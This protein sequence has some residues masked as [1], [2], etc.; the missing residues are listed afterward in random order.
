MKNEPSVF[1]SKSKYLEGLQCPKLL[2]YEFNRKEDFPEIALS[3]QFRFDQ[4]KK[5]GELAQKLFPGGI[6]LER[7]LDPDKCSQKSL[8]ALKQRKPLFEAGFVHNHGYAIADIIEPASDNAWDLIEVKS[9]ASVKDEHFYDVAFQKY[10]YEGAG[11]KIRDCYL[12]YINTKYVREGSIKPEKLFLQQNITEEVEELKREIEKK[13]AI[14]LRLISG[15]DMPDIKVG[16]QC[17]KPYVCALYDICWSFLPENDHV[18]I[19]SRI[20]KKAFEL[21]EKGILKLIDIPEGFKLSANQIIQVNSH[22]TGDPYVDEEAVKGFL[23]KLKYPLYFLDFETINPAVPLYDLSKPYERIP[24]QY[25]LHIVEKRGANPVHHSYLARGD[26]DPRLET[27]RQLRDLLG[28]VGSILVYNATFEIGVLKSSAE[29]HP[30]FKG[31]VGEIEKRIVDLYA[32][33]RSLSYYHPKQAGSSSLKEVLPALTGSTYEGLEISDGE[34][35][36]REYYRVTFDGGIDEK[37][38]QRVRA[39]L[40]KYCDLDTKGMIDILKALNEIVSI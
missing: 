1:I 17:D 31:W 8:E 11:L 9:S 15:K 30:E 3:T 33:F 19:L 26:A 4:G 28:N 39:A 14:M 18:F 22:R 27:L 13:M 32:P 20:G 29:A 37:E 23:E 38:R 7:D 10:V 6:K 25:S 24:F 12:L 34:M 16:E 21:R 36:S 5:V 2:W 35:A 40:E